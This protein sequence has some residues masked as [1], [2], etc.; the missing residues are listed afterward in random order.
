VVAIRA[1]VAGRQV[2]AIRAVV[3]ARPAVPP[4]GAEAGDDRYWA[5]APLRFDSVNNVS[6]IQSGKVR[7]FAIKEQRLHK[8][9]ASEKV[10]ILELNNEFCPA[11][12]KN[13][14]FSGALV[15]NYKLLTKL[16]IGDTCIVSI[17]GEFQCEYPSKVARIDSS[18]IALEFIGRH[19]MHVVNYGLNS[20]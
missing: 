20:H 2:V 13:I 14:S 1:V 9:F 4:R 15:H 12:V 3:A 7:R 17:N 16:A 5:G 11:T 10:C 18:N 6:S 19:K 8:R